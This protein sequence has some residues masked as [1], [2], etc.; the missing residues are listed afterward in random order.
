M[1]Q[2]GRA[3][4]WW[5][6]GIFGLSVVVGIVQLALP[7]SLTLTDS[8]LRYRT[9]GKSGTVAWADV[10]SFG[11]MSLRSGPLAPKMVGMRN[12]ADYRSDRPV[13]NLTR[14]ISGF[15]GALPETY[16]YKAEELVALLE[17]W[18]TKGSD[19]QV[20]VSDE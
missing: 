13:S 17:S 8:G 20:T 18:R 15:D 2:R 19:Q 11:V 3:D 4:G 5:I 10:A 12:T 7:G 6:V 14:D 1:V 16:G 9:P